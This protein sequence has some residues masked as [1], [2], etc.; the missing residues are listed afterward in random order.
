MA[1]RHSPFGVASLVIALAVG[2]GM[3]AVVVL[4]A[5]APPTTEKATMAVGVM[6]CAFLG[7]NLVGAAMGVVGLLQKDRSPTFSVLGASLNALIL[8]GVGVLMFFGIVLR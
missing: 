6:I 8:L 3:L 7:L 1:R 5:L 2:A 4:S